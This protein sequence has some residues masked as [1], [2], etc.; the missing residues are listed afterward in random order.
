MRTTYCINNLVEVIF[1]RIGLVWEEL[2]EL[3]YQR[4]D[5]AIRIIEQFFLLD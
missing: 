2:L 5:G 1:V 4:Q 3:G